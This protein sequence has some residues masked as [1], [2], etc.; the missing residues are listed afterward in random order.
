M[1]SGLARAASVLQESKYT[2]LAEQAITFIR[3]NLVDSSTKQL[4]RACYINQKTQQ[5]E[6]T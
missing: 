4:L 5:I 1:I 6:Y 2:Q 3:T